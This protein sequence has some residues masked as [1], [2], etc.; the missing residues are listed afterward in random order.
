MKSPPAHVQVREALE[1]LLKE[2]SATEDFRLPGEIQLAAQFGVSRMTVNKV[3]VAL[4]RDGFIR[5]EKGRGTF[6]LS[7]PKTGTRIA[8]ALVPGSL[9][10][11]FQDYYFGALY[12]GLRAALDRLGTEL[13]VIKLDHTLECLNERG[14]IAINPPESSIDELLS[15]GRSGNPVVLLGASWEGFSLSTVDSEN[16]LGAALA[17]NHLV[18]FGH[19][20]IIFLGACPGDSNTQD[21]VR[22]FQVAMKARGLLARP[23][24]I[25]LVE[26][27]YSLPAAVA[28]SI[29]NRVKLG[30]TAVF[31][32]G[33]H[34]A[35]QLMATATR[36]G[37]RVP[38][39]LSIVGYDDPSFL[40][41]VYPSLTT[42][43]QPLQQMA[44]AACEIVI[45]LQE[46][47]DPR[48]VRRVLDPELVVRESTGPKTNG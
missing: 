5:R 14:L 47:L 31:A 16:F 3:M 12:W 40:G 43:R 20:E 9:D 38:Q 29:F 27:A 13:E 7:R 39:D 19:R 25:V 42:I 4:E 8:L 46:S 34:L 24:D 35:V 36:Q 28:T 2:N 45:S 30:A 41:M 11:A 32:A 37:I 22:G 48:P 44:E 26:T 6:A 21:R 18:D 23:E 10:L 15:Y 33:P 1:Q 17:V